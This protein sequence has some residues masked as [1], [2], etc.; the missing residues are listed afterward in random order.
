[1][2]SKRGG[3]CNLA[4]AAQEILSFIPGRRHG[5]IKG[6]RGEEGFTEGGSH[7]NSHAS[8][9]PQKRKEKERRREGKRRMGE[10]E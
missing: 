6:E 3:V 7:P 10:G 5:G 9:V 4:A 1:L 2:P 8:I